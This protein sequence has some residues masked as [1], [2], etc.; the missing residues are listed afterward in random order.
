LEQATRE[1]ENYG[2]SLEYPAFALKR[3]G[4]H[5][6]KI[7]DYYG[8][9]LVYQAFALK[10][11]GGSLNEIM[12]LIDRYSPISDYYADI[13]K[14]NR[15]EVYIK[16]GHLEYVEQYLSWLESGHDV[17]K[18]L[19]IVLE[20]FVNSGRLEDARQ[21]LNR[22]QHLFEEIPSSKEPFRLKMYLHFHYTLALYL[23]ARNEMEEGLHKLLDVANKA[24]ELGN[25]DRF[26][27]CLQIIWKYKFQ[28]KIE[29]EKKYLQ[30]LT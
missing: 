7:E 30:L 28:S 25:L 9:A 10:R 2:R 14:G 8:R 23:C 20:E 6:K 4:W 1:G 12:E 3:L 11:L 18:G 5:L 17:Y 24:F 27:Q 21:L 22:Y 16:L 19:P 29:H 15:L 26:K 13:A